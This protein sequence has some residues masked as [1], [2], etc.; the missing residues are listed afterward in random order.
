MKV[1]SLLVC[2]LLAAPAVAPG[3]NR[4]I[5][6]LQRD[7]GLLQQQIRDLQKS[8]DDKFSALFDLAKQAIEAS[9]KANT[10]VAAVTA[11]VQRAL[12]PLKESLTA[13]IAA[14]NSRVTATSEDVRALQQSVGD[15]S[16]AVTRMQQQLNDINTLVKSLQQLPPPPAQA[17]GGS[18]GGSDGGGPAANLPPRPQMPA[19]DLYNAALSDYRSGKYDL[20]V[21]EFKEYLRRFPT[22]KFAPNA[23]FYIG[24]VHY[25]AR[26]YDAAAA[27]FDAVL[28][29]YVYNPKTEDSMLY[30]GRSLVKLGRKTEG[31]AEF[32]QLL[33]EYPRADAAK[34]ACEDLKG[35]GMNCTVP[36]AS[37]RAPGRRSK[38]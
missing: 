28:E 12:A 24:Q 22:E 8:Q 2:V 18:V 20:A 35:L 14:M 25:E 31:A 15:L 6:D 21:D 5:Q 27:D 37:N 9:N 13:P 1:R 10:G 17:I 4:E 38:K 30:K 26:N 32:K 19:G 16:S 34:S 36:G 33:K 29:H 11:D 7:V 23:Q 3:A